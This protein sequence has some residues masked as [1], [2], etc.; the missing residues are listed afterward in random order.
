MDLKK[1]FLTNRKEESLKVY[2]AV[3]IHEFLIKSAVWKINSEQQPEII[4][5]G[6]FEMWDSQESLINGIDAS[7]TNAVKDLPSQPNEVILGLS[8]HW[9]EKDKI[10]PS[11]TNLIKQI[12]KELSLKPLGMVT[13][14]QAIIHHL[15]ITD[16]VPPTTILLEVYPTKVTVTVVKLGEI[17]A[18]EEAG[19][20]GDLSKDVE[21]AL[22][23]LNL[24]QLPSQFLLT[25]GSNLENE[26]QQLMSHSWKEK[27]SFLHLPKVEVLP[28]DFSIEA[29]ALSGGLE[30]VK[31]L[32]VD[33]ESKDSKK[34]SPALSP[35]SLPT[36]SGLE[37]IGFGIEETTSSSVPLSASETSPIDETNHP[38]EVLSAPKDPENKKNSTL[39]LISKT[40][41]IFPNLLKSFNQLF[42]HIK[43]VFISRSLFKHWFI[44]PLLIFILFLTTTIFYLF[45]GKAQIVLTLPSQKIE[46]TREVV[47]STISQPNTIL[48]ELKNISSQTNQTIA[49]TGEATVGDRASGKVAIYNRTTEPITLASGTNI[50]S[51]PDNL[52]YTLDAEVTIASKSSDLISGEEKFGK[53]M[54][55]AVTADRIGVDYNISQNTNFTVGK[56]SKT[57]LYAIG[58]NDFGGGSSRAVKAVSQ[59][60]KETLLSLAT[61]EVEQSIDSQI[62]QQ[63][64]DLLSIML[65]EAQFDQQNFNKETGEEADELN[66]DLSANFQVLICSKSEIINYLN[67]EIKKEHSDPRVL[68]PNKTNFEFTFPESISENSYTSQLKT[69]G[70]LISE[71]ET[72]FLVE[73]IVAM[74]VNKAQ[75][76]LKQ[77]TNFE[78]ATIFVKPKIPFLS[79]MLPARKN[80]IILEIIVPN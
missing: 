25:N 74:S 37:D 59:E 19:R 6:S 9:L 54:G 68:A 30:V 42:S 71:I 10:H 7:L 16:G 78:S 1:L 57:I 35:S 40:S 65:G 44:Y 28:I 14:T 62:K 56:Y 69:T 43:N 77:S 64:T 53:A 38:E 52:I 39:P 67:Q 12:L 76:K 75:E 24:D 2:L 18:S 15:K 4:S 32:S 63:N 61:E 45:F 60:D 27:L 55:V 23:R 21:E 13:V 3:E 20:S 72:D 73:Q 11:K 70:V 17:K 58:E 79:K 50:V 80:N 33:I 46:E 31:V 47:L 5:F 29:I 36:P 34:T 8:E 48:V 49:T 22:T 41:P 26:Q 51:D 66:L